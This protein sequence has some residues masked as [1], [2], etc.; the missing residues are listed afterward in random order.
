[1]ASTMPGKDIRI[2]LSG[3]Y[4]GQESMGRLYGSGPQ[5][6]ILSNMNTNN[7]AEW[8]PLINPLTSS[9][10]AVLTYDYVDPHNDQSDVLVDV[11]AFAKLSGA[12]MVV[13]I[14]A[15]RGGVTSMQVAIKL[16]ADSALVGAVA[17]S[18]PVEHEGVV[19]F[20]NA[21]LGWI[22]VPKLL[23]N[24]EHDECAAGTIQ[25][26]GLITAPK[27][28]IFYD[29]NEHG[30]DIFTTKRGALVAVLVNFVDSVMT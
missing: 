1:M 5:M 21:E 15:S 26:F 6:V 23:I 7:Q 20:S 24:T 16:N 27:T 17:L 4:A 10:Y 8:E 28:M 11:I 30:T 25:M 29:G 14:G 19:F 12:E 9:G 3:S 22:K 18:A 2:P 13:L